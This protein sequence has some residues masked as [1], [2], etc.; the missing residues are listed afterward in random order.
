MKKGINIWAFPEDWELARS[1]ALAAEAGFDGIE[2]AYAAD[3][4]I[5]PQVTASELA[6]LRNAARSAGLEISSLASGIFWSVNLISDDTQEREA[7]KQHLRRMLEIAA[8][9][10]VGYI[11]VVPGFAG[12]FEAGNPVIRDYEETY[13]RAIGDFQELASTAD[14]YKV[15]IGIENVWNKF[16]SSAMEL[17]SFI[18]AVGNPWV[19]AYFDVA[20]CLRTGYPEHWIRLLGHRIIG[21]H[22]KDFRTNVGTLEGFVD[23][24]EGDVDY[25]QVMDA[26][27][28]VG[29][30]G[31][32][33]VEVFSRALYPETVVLRAGADIRHV[34]AVSG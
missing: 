29:Y 31:Y 26:L 18:D 27:R 9:L 28:E 15:A 4:P 16:L 1:F 23:L 6:D 20:N 19:G 34:F 22:F 21:I 13:Q 14:E 30:D 17:R 24:F 32:C 5:H 25:P 7:A 3:G 12:P 8:D 33:V 2:L 11:L 10:E